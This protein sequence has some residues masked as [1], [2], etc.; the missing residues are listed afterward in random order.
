[1][2][3]YARN[4]SVRTRIFSVYAEISGGIRLTPVFD[5]CKRVLT[6]NDVM[7]DR[8]GEGLFFV[9]W[10]KWPCWHAQLHSTNC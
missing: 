9:S 10:W 1:M 3:G 2:V 8:R 4:G 7:T 6:V 5:T